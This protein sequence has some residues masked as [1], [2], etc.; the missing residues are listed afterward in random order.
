MLVAWS[1]D[2]YRGIHQSD[3][4]A[5]LTPSQ[6]CEGTLHFLGFI[7]YG[8]EWHQNYRR[9]F[10]HLRKKFF[11][12]EDEEQ[13]YIKFLNLFCDNHDIFINSTNYLEFSKLDTENNALT[14]LN[15][16]LRKA[17]MWLALCDYCLSPSIS[18]VVRIECRAI[19]LPA[20]VDM[21]DFLKK[22][23]DV[24]RREGDCIGVNKAGYDKK[25]VSLQSATIKC[26]L[27]IIPYLEKDDPGM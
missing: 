5:E 19:L 4:D 24:I 1:S 12:E 9:L 22:A 3:N 21:I 2:A 6:I 7:M 11:P 23:I 25:I 8:K 18:E 27:R 20:M 15:W 17:F 14:V 10:E 26:L 13:S 16:K